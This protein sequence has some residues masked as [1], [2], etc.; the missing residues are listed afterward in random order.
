MTRALLCSGQGRVER[1]MFDLLAQNRRARAVFQAAAEQLGRDPVAFLEEASA[2]E[3]IEDRTGQ[4]LSVARALA[5]G[6]S[7]E[8]DAPTMIA[9]YSVGEMA[10]W[11]LAGI[12]APGR[13]LR[14]TSRRAE[15]M[16]L[17]DGG[18]GGLGFVRGLDDRVLGDLLVRHGCAIAIRNPGRMYIIG[19]VRDD[20]ARCCAA[21]LGLGAAGARPIPVRVAS[22]TS[23]LQGAV[24]PFL[25]ILT[26]EPAARP[27]AKVTLIGAADASIVTNPEESLEGLARQVATTID[28]NGVLTA[29]VER[30][31]RRFLELGPG[32]AL[33]DMVRTGWPD[34][35]VRSFDD[36]RTVEGAGQWFDA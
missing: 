23:R 35:E 7:L 20:I 28:W 31:A 19:G 8:I 2:T 12:W 32:N 36:F 5:A 29:L 6:A 1:E 21:A 11:S 27:D 34:L 4:I 25:R 16:E 13:V 24:D 14:L 17:A 22:H 9:G 33:A 26:G 3:L 15:L 18:I 30:G 10:A